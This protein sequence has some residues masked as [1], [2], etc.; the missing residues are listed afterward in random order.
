MF[1]VIQE[2]KG[3]TNHCSEQRKKELGGHGGIEGLLTSKEFK[4]RALF[5]YRSVIYLLMGEHGVKD[6]HI[7][8]SF[9]TAC[10]AFQY[11]T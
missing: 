4:F 5:S 3:K 2:L 8:D 7:S 6:A 9:Q 11:V 1:S 10:R